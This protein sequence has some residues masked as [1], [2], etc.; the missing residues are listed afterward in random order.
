MRSLL[1]LIVCALVLGHGANGDELESAVSAGDVLEPGQ[2]EFTSQM[3]PDLPEPGQITMTTSNHSVTISNSGPL[4]P[5]TRP[6]FS[7]NPQAPDHQVSHSSGPPEPSTKPVFTGNPSNPPE[8]ST[9]PHFSSENTR[10]LQ[11]NP[12]E[13]STRPH[14]SSNAQ[15]PMEP[16]TRPHFSQPIPVNTPRPRIRRPLTS[17]Y[18]SGERP[19]NSGNPRAQYQESKSEGQ[20]RFYDKI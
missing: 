3:L 8:P 19:P 9:R 6:H 4:E 16:S 7:G 2:L 17:S 18:Y 10:P 11:P 12:P 13:P 20:A 5:S 15:G 14:F 1:L